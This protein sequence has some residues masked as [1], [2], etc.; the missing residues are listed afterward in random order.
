MGRTTADHDP[1]INTILDTA[2]SSNC[3]KPT[4]ENGTRA[5]NCRQNL[6]GKSCLSCYCSASM[7]SDGRYGP[8]SAWQRG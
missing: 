4:N 2:I 6:V 8:Q 5:T 3:G 1:Y 7:L